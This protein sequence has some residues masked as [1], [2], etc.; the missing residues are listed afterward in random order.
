[1]KRTALVTGANSGLGFEAAAQLAQAGYARVILACRT[2]EKAER[3]RQQLVERVGHDPFETLAI[4]VADLASSQAA[5]ETL[6]ARNQAIDALLLNAGLVPGD[7]L[8]TSKDGHEL[9]FAASVVGHHVLTMRLLAAGRLDGARIVIAGSEAAN[10]DLP[11]MMGMSVYDFATGAP[12]TFGSTLREAMLAFA[13]AE[14]PEAYVGTR[15]YSTTKV[16]SA[17]WSAALA[18]RLG[19]RASVFT[20]SP[21]SNLSTNAA[22]NTR[23]IQRFLFTRVMPAIGSL[24]GWD[25]PVSAGARRYLDVLDGGKAFVSGRTYTSAPGKM[26]G[27]LHEV[28]MLHITDVERQ[29]TA[30]DVLTTLTGVGFPAASD[31]TPA[32]LV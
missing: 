25:Q 4:D 23:G 12:R 24:I 7:T 18:R 32:P 28:T 21:G 29:E 20:V 8:S 26:V 22:R 14:R 1:M 2:L 15:T 16:F 13:R 17:W 9:S 27:A 6:I 30:W 31:L 19:D 5:A 3:A 11:S 10:N